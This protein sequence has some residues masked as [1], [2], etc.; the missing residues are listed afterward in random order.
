MAAILHDGLYGHPLG[1]PYIGQSVDRLLLQL[2]GI[3]TFSRSCWSKRGQ[4]TTGIFTRVSTVAVRQ[5]TTTRHTG[6][7]TNLD[8]SRR[9]HGDRRCRRLP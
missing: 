9:T 7:R 6:R 4:P 5:Q 2:P 3:Q 1:R 8:H